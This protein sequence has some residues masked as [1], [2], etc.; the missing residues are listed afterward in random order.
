[1]TSA[2]VLRLEIGLVAVATQY[3]VRNVCCIL[4]AIKHYIS[5][6]A[7]AASLILFSVYHFDC[8]FDFTGSGDTFPEILIVPQP[9][10]VPFRGASL[11][12]PRRRMAGTGARLLQFMSAMGTFSV[13]D[14]L[15]PS[16]H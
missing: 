10:V 4:L 5:Y 16:T 8:I 2:I 14:N 15:L 11:L 7:R 13:R 12:L 6:S 9:Q 1:M 3:K